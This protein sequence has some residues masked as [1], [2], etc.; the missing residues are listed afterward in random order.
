MIPPTLGSLLVRPHTRPRLSLVLLALCSAASSF[1]SSTPRSTSRSS[2]LAVLGLIFSI[3]LSITSILG[4]DYD[5]NLDQFSTSCSA[6]LASLHL[7]PSLL[8]SYMTT[9]FF[10]LLTC[11]DPPSTPCSILPLHSMSLY[12]CTII[13]ITIVSISSNHTQPRLGFIGFTAFSLFPD[14]AVGLTVAS[15]L[16]RPWSL[17]RLDWT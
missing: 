4:Y 14:S 8:A 2:L 6:Q 9:Y 7:L 16:T 1:S 3:L 11:L 13:N 12:L 5:S 17:L 15:S 10:P